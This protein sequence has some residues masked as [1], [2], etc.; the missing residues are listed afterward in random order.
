MSTQQVAK[1]F[2]LNMLVDQNIG[3][4][5][6][7]SFSSENNSSDYISFQFNTSNQIDF[8]FQEHK[9]EELQID[10]L[11]IL[12]QT[13]NF[14]VVAIDITQGTRT[15]RLKIYVNGGFKE[16]DFGTSTTNVSQS[17]LAY[18]S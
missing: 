16:T 7:T 10:N 3:S 15:D 14:I 18:P 8:Q 4:E 1:V 9:I 13:V 2:G 5:G 11:G 12:V 17:G 6:F